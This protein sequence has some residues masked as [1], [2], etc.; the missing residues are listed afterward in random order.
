MLH[1]APKWALFFRRV[2]VRCTEITVQAR[3]TL[4]RPGRSE[5]AARF[6]LGVGQG[7]NGCSGSTVAHALRP[8]R[9]G[10]NC[11]KS[12]RMRKPVRPAQERSSPLRRLV[13][14][15]ADI[16]AAQ[17]LLEVVVKAASPGSGAPFKDPLSGPVDRGDMIRRARTACELRER[18]LHSFTFHAE[19]PFALLLVLYANEEWEPIVTLTRLTHLA[20]MSVSTCIRW[21]EVLETQGLINR[22]DDAEDKRKTLVSLSA[23]GRGSLDELFQ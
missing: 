23:K 1:V 7:L 9:P 15:E 19:A 16:A 20:W 2:D 5:A 21:L 18:R 8:L 6:W 11:R 13:V 17:R 12:K 3:R 4:Q 14:A 10:R 22:K